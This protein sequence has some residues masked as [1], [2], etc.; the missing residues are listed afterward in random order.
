[1]TIFW[2]VFAI[3]F[4]LVAWLDKTYCM[5]RDVTTAK[6][7]QPYSW[8]RVQ[9]AWWTVIVL[10]TFI[11]IFISKG[12]A[13]TLHISTVILLGISSATTVT[14]RAID[15]SDQQN[16]LISRHQNDFGKNF[17]LDIL[18]D[19]NG[20]SINRFQTLMFNVVF[21]IWFINAVLN[22]MHADCSAYK[23]L[24]G[25]AVQAACKI[26][27]IDYIMPVISDNN[28]IL[29]GLSSA[30]YAALKTTEN[31]TPSIPKENTAV[32][33]SSIIAVGNVG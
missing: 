4:V 33:D 31:K 16:L 29:L 1:M 28:L 26:N 27:P 18:S 30:T 21:G 6:T 17:L 10:A 25:S 7:R 5:L 24:T 22:N 2:I 32:T 19:E 13:P 3:T 11:A 23:D 14:A 8:S 15:L 20:V 12:V 9:L